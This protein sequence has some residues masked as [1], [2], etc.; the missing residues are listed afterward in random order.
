MST[1]SNRKTWFVYHRVPFNLTG[2]VLYPLNQLK[3]VYPKVAVTKLEK[4]QGREAVLNQR[5]PYLNCLWNDVLHF[6]PV[7]PA[8]IRAALEE[9]GR[10]TG[11][12]R[13]RYYE[14][15]AATFSPSKTIIWEYPARRHH[16]FV[17]NKSE[18]YTFEPRLLDKYT[19]VG[20]RTRRYYAHV[21]PGA[22]IL[23]YVGVAHVLYKGHLNIEKIKVIE[24]SIKGKGVKA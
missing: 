4:Y 5:I 24:V 23:P 9:A 22:H 12:R 6:S 21:K 11:S 14:V 8:R 3:Q 16:K 7:H 15:D 2:S 1:T 19:K 20:E 17:I 10:N 18:C 13:W